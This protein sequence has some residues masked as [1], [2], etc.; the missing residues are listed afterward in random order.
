MRY[1]FSILMVIFIITLTQTACVR[2]GTTNV[3]GL[4]VSLY[5]GIEPWV[6]LGDSQS[7]VMSRLRGQWDKLDI[8]GNAELAAAGVTEALKLS[9]HGVKAYFRNDRVVLIELQSPF[10]GKIQGRKV[11]L[12]PYQGRAL[13]SWEETLKR[14]FG[15]PNSQASGG[16]LGSDCFFYS[17]GDISFNNVGANQLAL[18]RDASIAAYRQKNYGR[19]LKIFD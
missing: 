16:G 19:V 10:E 8:S 11:V 18:Y 1:F 13:A 7:Q 3:E 4:T 6:R 12:F 17:W 5:F 2:R 15:P 9:D 14:D